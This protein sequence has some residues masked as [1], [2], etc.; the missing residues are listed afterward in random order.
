MKNLTLVILLTLSPLSWANSF[1]LKCSPVT[2]DS[3]YD[4]LFFYNKVNRFTGY[5]LTRDPS[6]NFD[7]EMFHRK[8]GSV[9]GEPRYHSFDCKGGDYQFSKYAEN[10]HSV[11]ID[12]Q[13]LSLTRL[14][15]SK[16]RAT[17]GMVIGAAFQCDTVSQDTAKRTLKEQKRE[18]KE[19]NKKIKTRDK[20]AKQAKEK[21]YRI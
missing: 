4:A 14:E 20:A 17:S 6:R 3:E 16:G 12:R 9:H 21:G 18:I 8:C 1:A 7:N 2:E 11:I 19:R 5:Y 10:K 15:V 13:D